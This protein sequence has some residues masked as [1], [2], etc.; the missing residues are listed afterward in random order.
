M[1]YERSD[2]T[3]FTLVAHTPDEWADYRFEQLVN[4]G[5]SVEYAKQIADSYRGAQLY[6]SQR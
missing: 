1:I 2:E 4:L 3:R 5:C 6:G